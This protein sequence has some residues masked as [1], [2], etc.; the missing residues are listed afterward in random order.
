MRIQSG[1]GSSRGRWRS[2]TTAVAAAAAAA[3]LAACGAVDT[4]SGASGSDDDLDSSD[5]GFLSQA[6][7]DQLSSIVDKAE[8][9]P[10]FVSPGKAFDISKAKGKRL[11]VIPTASQ[12]PVCQQIAESIVKLAPKVGMSGKVFDNSGG[13]SG[14]IPGI[15][16]AISQHYDAIVLVCGIDPNLIG[17][18]LQ[19]AKRAGIAV[20]D[21]GL[22]DIEK[23]EATNPLVTAQTN[24]PNME[25]MRWAIDKAI[26]DNR[27]EPFHAFVITSNDVPS[28]VDMYGA[29]KGEFKKYCPDC[30]VTTT[31]IAVPDWATKV[32][33]AVSSALQA[34][35]DIKAVIPI[36]DG[37][38]PPAAAGIR[39]SGRDDVFIYGAYGG[40]P[41]YVKA[42][43]DSIPM[44]A[45]VG[46]TQ[47]WRAYATMDQTLRVLSGAGA[48]PPS[49]DGDPSRLW[50]LSNH[51]EVTKVNNGF[52]TDFQT[53]YEKL[54]GVS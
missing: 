29:L 53:E 25:A 35:P 4:G 46:P 47:L 49:K 13:A 50:T 33:S 34:N 22:T 6:Q 32:Q 51:D 26:L 38:V 21:S 44:K 1:H 14:W 24:L 5:T 39:A 20:I 28:G 41:E 37:E 11:F 16:Q 3:T 40:T 7:Y 48:V 8:A 54:W 31:N 36:F 43:G 27:K 17:P 30:K 10:Q 52:G 12:L 9:V 2:V 42:M 18:Q 45:D 15:Q 23:G 19:A